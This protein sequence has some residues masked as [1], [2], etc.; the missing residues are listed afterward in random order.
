M[1]LDVYLNGEPRTVTCRCSDCGN[2]HTTTNEEVLFSQNTTHNHGADEMVR[3]G[4]ATDP[5]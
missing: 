2:E 3:Q 1:S 5:A 4:R